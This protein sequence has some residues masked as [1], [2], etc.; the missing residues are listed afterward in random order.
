MSFMLRKISARAIFRTLDLLTVWKLPPSPFVEYLIKV[1]KAFTERVQMKDAAHI[2]VADFVYK[3]WIG[4]GVKFPKCR[5]S[6]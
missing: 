5:R 3:M 4:E 1:S 6:L 2:T